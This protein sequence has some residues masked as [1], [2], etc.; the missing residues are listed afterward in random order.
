MFWPCGKMESE[1]IAKRIYIG[2]CVGSRSVGRPKKMWIDTMNGFL[3]K[4]GL[5]DRQARRMMHDMSEW[6]GCIGM[7]GTYPGR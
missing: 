4:R 6:W 5:D 7:L 3:K 2:E 1:R